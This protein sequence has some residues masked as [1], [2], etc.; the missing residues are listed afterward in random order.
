MGLT[1]FFAAASAASLAASAALFACSC[2]TSFTACCNCSIG[3]GTPTA[4]SFNWENVEESVI[5]FECQMKARPFPE[6]DCPSLASAEVSCLQLISG[7]IAL[8][9]T[10]LQ[11][12]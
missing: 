1:F 10:G 2:F 6:G 11:V 3:S 8:G 5:G 7:S 12:K 4:D 9:M